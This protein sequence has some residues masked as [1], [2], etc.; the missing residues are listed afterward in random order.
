MI[1]TK[2]QALKVSKRAFANIFIPELDGELR[3]ASLS[4]GKAAV[5]NF[6]RAKIDAGEGSKR[7][8]L[9]A[10]V[11]AAVVDENGEQLFD[12]ASAAKFVDT[13]SID[14]V[15]LIANSIPAPKV[16]GPAV[17]PGNSVGSTT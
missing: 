8:F 6:L 2:D 10:C 15:L 4:A 3:L 17:P 13:A 11:Q 9:I 12:T 1:L 7:E 5:I 14:A 16:D